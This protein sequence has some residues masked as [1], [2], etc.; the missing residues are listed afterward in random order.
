MKRILVLGINYAPEEIGIAV[1]TTG[2]C[3]ALAARGVEV[4]V[5]TTWPYYPHW[6]ADRPAWRL[7]GRETRHGVRILRCP[8]YVPR[9]PSGAKRM[10]HHISFACSVIVPLTLAALRRRP[11]LVL[12][13][14]PSLVAAPAA[15][16]AARLARAPS[17]LHIQD[18]ELEAALATGLIGR[19]SRATRLLRE[20]EQRIYAGFTRLSSISREMCARL[21]TRNEVVEIRNW[22]DDDIIPAEEGASP[23]RARWGIATPHV[24]LYSGNIALKQGIEL[25]LEAAARLAHRTDLTFVICGNGP[26]RQRVD[27]MAAALPN[28]R[29]FDLQP[30]ADLDDLLALAT[31]HLLPQ[32]AEAAGLVLPSKLTN[33][34]ASGRPVVV[35]AAPGTDLAEEVEGCGLVTP[36]GD[37]D[38]FAV[39]IER[40][41]DD[42][43]LRQRQGDAAWIRARD[44]W[45]RTAVVDRFVQAVAALA[46]GAAHRRTIADDAPGR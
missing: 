43:S 15:T 2:L 17:W 10:L 6:L 11:D 37:A 24:A 35:T 18:F 31:V 21:S 26:T 29:V 39:A 14:A 30:K 41:L 27:A 7:Y 19:R 1:Y 4:E 9:T 45:A 33:M 16:I 32:R 23:Y 44:T 28:V 3:E 22:A 40:L 38:A 42:A 25:V 8:I 36:P 20:I 46:P 12:C 5:V 13:V 34:L